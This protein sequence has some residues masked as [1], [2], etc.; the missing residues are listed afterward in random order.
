MPRAC[1]LCIPLPQDTFS[2]VT[3]ASGLGI[4]GVLQVRR[5]GS[6]EAAA[7]FSRQLRGPEQRYSATELEALAVVESI[8]HFNYYLYGR[9][10]C[11]FTD[12][13]PLLQLLTSEHL[14]RRLRRFAYKLQHWLVKIQYLPGIENSLA[15]PLS[16]EE[17]RRIAETPVGQPEDLPLVI[18]PLV[19]DVEDQPPQRRQKSVGGS[20]P[21]T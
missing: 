15:D 21:P 8:I 13:K 20:T 12:H 4:G 19:G 2:L 18:G 7:Y 14:N 9:A 17:R 6:W 1:S 11:V 16:R 5:H 3:D 10:F